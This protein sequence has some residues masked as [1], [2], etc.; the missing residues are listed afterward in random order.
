MDNVKD[1]LKEK[2]SEVWAIDQDTQVYD[3][4][5]MMSEKNIGALLVVDKDENL[6]GIFSERDYA[7]SAV[8]D[9]E[10]K[11]CPWDLPVKKLMTTSV[12]YITPGKSVEYCMGLM[13]KRRL[14]HLPVMDGKKLVGL[15]SIGDVVKAVLS[16]KNFIIEQMEHYI[17]DNT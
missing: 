16:E 8:K 2:G 15:I 7:R 3:A 4:L 14:R 11:E 1:M 12:V 13:T 5:T 10:K 17:W 9:P 6:Q